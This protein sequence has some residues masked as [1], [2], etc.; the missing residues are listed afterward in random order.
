MEKVLA[1]VLAGGKGERLYPLTRDRAKPAVPFGGIYR[2]IDF[3]LSNCVNSGIRQVYVLTQYK[4]L[5][6]IQH[7][8]QGW[9]SFTTKLGDFIR[10]ATAEQRLDETWYLGTADAVFQN[11]YILQQHRPDI[12]LILS[13]DHIYKMNYDRLIKYHINKNA[14]LTIAAIELDAGLSRHFGVMEVDDSFRIVGF[15]EKP[16]TPRTIPG[17]PDKIL[18]SMGI[19]VFKTNKMVKRLIEDAKKIESSH[20]FG[21]NIIPSMIN[22]DRVY[23]YSFNTMGDDWENYWRDVGTID[24]YVEAQQDLLKPKPPLRLFDENWP[25]YTLDLSVPPTKFNG[26]TEVISS[27]IC[28]GCRIQNAR[29]ENSIIYPSVTIQSGA[30]ITNSIIMNRVKVGG[31]TKIRNTIVDKSVNLPPNMKIGHNLKTDAKRFNVT[32]SGFVII[33]RAEKME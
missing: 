30:E 15:Q 2:I 14:E 18:A 16:E 3:T 31:N 13:G 6:L 11:I 10:L 32:E 20:D 1:I 24:A 7:I 28:E 19:Y 22:R 33:P 29:I 4:S 25:I 23:A 26:R 8:Q 12:T 17:K 21:K 9:G 27:I 5:S